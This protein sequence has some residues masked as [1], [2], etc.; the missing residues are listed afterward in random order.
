MQKY[1]L[2]HIYIINPCDVPLEFVVEN[3]SQYISTP[4]TG[5]LTDKG[6]RGGFSLAKG[7]RKLLAN[8]RLAKNQKY[9]SYFNNPGDFSLSVSYGRASKV[10]SGEQIFLIL[11]KNAPKKDR[12]VN[13]YLPLNYLSLCPL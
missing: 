8:F 10:I 5:I 11:E 1:Y 2:A 13:D 7:E 4:Y 3:N 12:Y 9:I 6:N